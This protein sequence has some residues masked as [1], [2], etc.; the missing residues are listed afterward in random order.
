MTTKRTKH[1]TIDQANAMAA[2]HAEVSADPIDPALWRVQGDGWTETHEPMGRADWQRFL[3]EHSGH[4][5]DGS[6]TGEGRRAKSKN[7]L[8]RCPT[9]HSGKGL[10]QRIV[11][12][13]A[14]TYR[15]LFCNETYRIPPDIKTYDAGQGSISIRRRT[16]A[17]RCWTT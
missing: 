9:T 14:G 6:G 12:L 16:T 11:D 17:R 13:D 10:H 2:G 15:C 5:H 3:D 7:G 4:D 8:K 1:L